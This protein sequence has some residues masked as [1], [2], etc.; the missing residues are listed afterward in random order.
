VF[1]RRRW[2]AAAGVLAGAA[3][4]SVGAAAAT[5]AWRRH[6]A[7]A[8]ER[9]MD[10]AAGRLRD[11]D[12]GR[13][14][15]TDFARVTTWDRRAGADPYALAE[16][17]G[18]ASLVGTLRGADAVVVLDGGLHE[19]QRL[20][21]PRAPT[22]LAVAGDAV[23]VA[24]ELVP[25]GA[26]SIA[27][28]RWRGGA[29]SPAG[30]AA[31][32]GV[33]AIRGL[34]A[35]EG[36]WLY[37]VEEERGRL[38]ALQAANPAAPALVFARRRELPI[39][40]GPARLQRLGDRLIVDCILDHALVIQRLDPGGAPAAEPP[41]RIVH[42]GPIW[43]FA[44]ARDATGD[45]V[46]AAGGVEDHPLDRTIGSFGYVDSFL[47]LYRVDLGAGRATRLAA[48]DVSDHG[49]VVPKALT[50][51]LAPAP[52]VRVAGYGTDRLLE[53]RFEGGSPS[54]SSR[55][56][57]PGTN[58]VVERRDG[59]L[60]FADPLLDAWVAERAG[61]RPEVVPVSA[62]GQ[63]APD[64]DVR[65]GEALIFT[66]L[67]APWNRSDG[68]L[69]R[70]TCE[71][72]HFEGYTDGRTHATGR[73]T[74]HAV[75]KSLLGLYNNR[76]HFS[77]ALDA[78]LVSVA[79]N[80]FR[81]A[82]ARSDHDPWFS[83]GARDVPWLGALGVGDERLSPERLRRAFISFLM[84]FNHRPNPAAVGRAAFSPEERAGAALFRDR[85]ESCHEARL[86]SDA[87]ESRV[88]FERW[89]EMVMARDGAIVW[90]KAEYKKT[91]VIP[92]VHEEGARVP[93]LRRLYKKHPYFTNGSAPD[94]EAV[95]A[96]ARFSPTDFWH[97]GGG[98][99]PAGL[100]ALDAREREVLL[101]FIEIL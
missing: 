65:L 29:L 4:L 34:A 91:G 72:C 3:A 27:R 70:F 86:E 97:E 55:E 21:A 2:L 16:L 18:S 51:A 76:P 87:P 54:V 68:P 81:V 82:G 42:D 60:V 24:G 44:A 11:F 69:S 22:A 10:A 99:A 7:A 57:V 46:I 30:T 6:A 71:T 8:E 92:Y 64:P 45:L 96:R 35:G 85:C 47:Y 98:D 73:G 74:V 83:L 56:I 61:G 41:V 100:A 89:E 17:P 77:R 50:L 75:T 25:E 12:E 20:P 40:N 33:H 79:F 93:S 53:V 37:A 101:A 15:A 48:L 95:L 43:G 80:E 14:A 49:V 90:G 62:P 5:R 23:Y 26:P 59:A 1:T 31:L 52:V 63:P 67:I 19:V 13:R 78:D 39:G 66:T 28:F 36:G 88:P 9:A 32:P 84:A 94:L 58:A 38:V